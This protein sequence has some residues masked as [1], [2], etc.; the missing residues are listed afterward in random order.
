MNVFV[1]YITDGYE[2]V[3]FGVYSTEAQANYEGEKYCK[4]G[5]VEGV[6]YETWVIQ[7]HE[8]NGNL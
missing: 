7:E 1:L 2:K 8:L 4:E 6:Q 5:E 3:I